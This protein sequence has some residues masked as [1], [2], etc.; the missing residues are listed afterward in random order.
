MLALGLGGQTDLPR[1]LYWFKAANKLQLTSHQPKEYTLRG[2]SKRATPRMP[3][4]QFALGRSTLASAINEEEEERGLALLHMA[5][6]GKHPGAQSYLSQLYHQGKHVP[7]NIPLAFD[8]AEKAALSGDTDAQYALGWFYANGVGIERNLTKADFWFEKAHRKGHQQA[9]SSHRFVQHQIAMQTVAE[10]PVRHQEATQA[11]EQARTQKAQKVN[12][13]LQDLTALYQRK[14]EEAK[15]KKKE[16]RVNVASLEKV[17]KP[18]AQAAPTTK[19]LTPAETEHIV[20]AAQPTTIA[21]VAAEKEAMIAQAPKKGSTMIGKLKSEMKNLTTAYH[22]MA[23]SLKQKMTFKKES[24]PQV[25]FIEPVA[26]PM[27]ADKNA[28]LYEKPKESQE[29]E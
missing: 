26:S 4:E 1:A 3:D 28:Y 13:K 19:L 24:A 10:A 11:K 27:T 17:A 2:L 22:R 23:S 7:Q 8:Y 15:L 6:E 20:Q 16:K 14:L 25:A 12:G 21:Q 9:R 5:A 18:V 29:N